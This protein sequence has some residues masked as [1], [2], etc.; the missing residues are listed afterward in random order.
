M[1]LFLYTISLLDRVSPPLSVFLL[2][3]AMFSFWWQHFFLVFLTPF[4]CSNSLSV[5][6]STFFLLSMHLV[7]IK[8]INH[9]FLITCLQNFGCLFQFVC[10]FLFY[11]KCPYLLCLW[12]CGLCVRHVQMFTVL[13]FFVNMKQKTFLIIWD[14]TNICIHLYDVCPLTAWLCA[15]KQAMSYF[16]VYNTTWV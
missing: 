4:I 12:L 14:S 16:L 3:L 9:S 1:H 5:L 11:L 13:S 6:L 10:S 2:L 7:S 15:P 8:F